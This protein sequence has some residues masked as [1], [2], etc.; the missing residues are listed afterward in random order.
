MECEDEPISD[1]FQACY[2]AG[3]DEVTNRAPGTYDKKSVFDQG[4][5][6]G[7]DNGGVSTQVG[8][9]YLGLEE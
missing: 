2:S 5:E 3:N 7:P 9:R 6:D 4:D 8:I 1:R